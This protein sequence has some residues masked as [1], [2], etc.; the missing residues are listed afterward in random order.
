MGLMAEAHVLKQVEHL[1]KEINRHNYRYHAL[2]DPVI[3]DARYDRLVAE[4]LELES[5]HPD[6]ITTDSP[7]QRVGVARGEIYSGRA[8]RSH[9]KFRQC[10]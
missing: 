8:C 7:T 2:D 10:L 6:L 3:S 4:L 5:Q 9:A 1:R